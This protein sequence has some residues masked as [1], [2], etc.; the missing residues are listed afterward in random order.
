[1]LLWPIAREVAAEP[2]RVLPG[3]FGQPARPESLVTFLAF[4]ALIAA[5]IG[6][7]ALGRIA[8]GRALRAE[9]AA[10]L[11]GAAALAPLAILVVAYTRVT[12]FDRSIPFALAAAG[13]AAA[14]AAAARGFARASEP[15]PA[16]RLALGATAAA[17]LAALALGLTFALEKGMLTVAFALM[18]LGTAWV[19]D[20]TALPVLRRAVAATGALVAA[21]L[22][23]DPTIVGGSPGATP[24]L[25][26]L[27]WGYGVPAVA[28]FLASRL[29]QR[30]GRDRITRFVESLAIAFAAFLVFFEIRH[31]VRGDV[32]SPLFDHLEAGLVCT[33]ALVFAIV[34]TRADLARGDPVYRIGSALFSALAV[35]VAA[36]GLLVAANPLLTGDPVLGGAVLNSLLAAYLLPAVLAGGLAVLARRAG[37]PP[38]YVRGAAALALVLHLA[39]LVMEIRHLFQGPVIDWNRPTGEAEQWCYSLALLTCGLVSLGLAAATGSRTLRVASLAYLAIAVVKVFVV[40][41][42]SLEGLMRALS[43]IG[44]G[45]TLIGIALVYQR[46]LARRPEATGA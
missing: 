33:E 21:R 26:W 31:A 29:L 11:A 30:H 34:L 13:L 20:R 36:G 25:N 9:I 39:W 2:P 40:D 18:A 4:G 22:V 45:L 7:G 19:A 1:M 43:F 42:S 12:A 32:A 5:T 17:S 38:A 24:I 46:L 28:F 16:R 14:F 10:C 15:T 6:A 3:P 35:V 23:W 37:R 8:R 44:L 27:L 41:L